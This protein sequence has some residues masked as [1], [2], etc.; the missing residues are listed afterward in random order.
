MRAS[1]AA[2]S[3]MWQLPGMLAGFV[4]EAIDRVV[5]VSA[6]MQSRSM[7]RAVGRV[8]VLVQRRS[9]WQV[10]VQAVMDAACFQGSRQCMDFWTLPDLAQDLHLAKR[11]YDKAYEMQ[12]DAFL[13]VR[14]ALAALWFQSCGEALLPFVPAS[15]APLAARLFTTSDS[16]QG[17]FSLCFLL[18]STSS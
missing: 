4:S 11:Q 5:P 13:A 3:M 2:S 9:C 17:V 8:A 12:R 6:C 18:A 10:K 15:V 16:G 7:L 14:L 1:A